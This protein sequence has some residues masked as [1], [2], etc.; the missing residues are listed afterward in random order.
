[1]DGQVITNWTLYLGTEPGTGRMII[2]NASQNNWYFGARTGAWYEHAGQA[3]ENRPRLR[4][5]FYVES[6]SVVGIRYLAIG[7]PFW[8]LILL[9]GVIAFVLWIPWRRRFSL[10]ALLIATTVVAVSLGLLVMMLRGS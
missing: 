5:R 2:L 9:S 7:S 8:L 4:G 6:G 3:S 10:R 1:M